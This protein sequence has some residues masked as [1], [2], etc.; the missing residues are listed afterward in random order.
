V[1]A[2]AIGERRREGSAGEG[3]VREMS[4]AVKA[5]LTPILLVLLVLLAAVC[6]GP[7]VVGSPALA[8]GAGGA[9]TGGPEAIRSETAHREVTHPGWSLNLAIYEVNVR[10]YSP[11]GTFKELEAHLPRLKDMGVGILWFMPIHPIGEKHRKGTLGS[12]YSV[13][14]YLAVNPEYGTLEEFNALVAKIH[15]L[16]MYVI[17]DWVANHC[18]WD[19]P[20]VESNPGWFTRDAAG[21]LKPPVADWADV[22]DLNY[23]QPGLRRYMIDAMKFWVRDVGIDGFRCDVAEMVPLDFW[24]EARAE[25][26]RIKPV[27]ML[28]EGEKAELHLGAFDATYGWNLFK[29]MRRVADGTASAPDLWAYFESDARA[30]PPDALRMYFTSNHDENSWNGTARQFFGEGLEAFAVL[31][32]TVKGIP[33]IYSGEEA[34][35]AKRLAFFDKDSIPWGEHRLA[36]LYTTLLGLKRANCALWNG[37]SGG[38]MV[39]VPT[40]KDGAVFAFLRE[41]DGDRVVVVANL[42]MRTQDVELRGKAFEGEYADVLEGKDVTLGNGARLKLKPW[43]YKLFAVTRARLTGG[44]P[45]KDAGIADAAA[46]ARAVDELNLLTSWMTGSFSS[47]EQAAADTDYY[48]VR[49]EMAP[50]W[51]ERTDGRWLYVEQAMAGSEDKPY[52][53]RVY[54]VAAGAPGVYESAVYAIPDPLRFAGEWKKPEPLAGLAPDSL[55]VRDGCAV[56]LRRVSVAAFEGGTVDKQCTSDLRGAAYATSQVRVTREGLTTWDRGFDAEGRQ[57]WGSTDAGYVFKRRP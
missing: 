31:T 19:N 17:I 11:A 13:R 30:Y 49:L 46:L 55:E 43:A 39:R 10:Q 12:Y 36:G 24:V 22:V 48:D 35:L 9:E 57:V 47:A 21:N 56:M 32:A 51:K 18:A 54:H 38:A 3:S 44:G 7:A 16:G 1:T 40:S 53:Q 27:F 14:D 8:V 20:L 33:L 37:E 52:R 28:A 34:G 2:R 6:C 23:D 25:L 45:R 42:S 15:D 41:K 29:L 4:A 50:I 5:G 26:D